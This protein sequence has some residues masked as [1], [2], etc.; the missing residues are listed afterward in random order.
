MKADTLKSEQRMAEN[1]DP[2]SGR[3]RSGHDQGVRP[4]QRRGDSGSDPRGLHPRLFISVPFGDRMAMRCVTR[5]PPW[6]EMPSLAEARR[7]ID[8]DANDCFFG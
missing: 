4:L 8:E 3:Q 6:V 2:R 1:G 5:Y 7:V